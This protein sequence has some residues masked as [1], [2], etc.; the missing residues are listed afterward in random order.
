MRIEFKNRFQAESASQSSLD[1]APGI[2]FVSAERFGQLVEAGLRPVVLPNGML[3]LIAGDGRV[4]T[5]EGSQDLVAAFQGDT[6]AALRELLAQV[7]AEQA[8][9]ENPAAVDGTEEPVTPAGEGDPEAEGEQHSN[10]SFRQDG[11]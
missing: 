11:V 6:D 7:A 2:E 5:Y 3:A 10:G 4:F 8:G 1:K 9:A